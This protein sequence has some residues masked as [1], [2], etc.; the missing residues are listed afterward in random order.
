[1]SAEAAG[2]RG[3]NRWMALLGAALLTN[4]AYAT[5]LHRLWDDRCVDCHGHAGEFARQHLQVVSGELIGRHHADLRRF[6]YN[7]YLPDAEVDAV[8]AM[9]RA[10]ADTTA[11]FAQRCSSCHKRA[12][13][14]ARSSLQLR[15]GKLVGV[16][17]GRPVEEFLRQHRD[18]TPDDAEFFTALLTRVHREVDGQ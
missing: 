2:T 17:T 6:L 4:A 12:A 11:Q 13:A 7:H 9:L 14:F 3:K 5:D 10:Q 18:L 15:S 1:M 8:Y 16:Q